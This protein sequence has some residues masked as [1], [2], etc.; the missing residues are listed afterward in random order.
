MERLKHNLSSI[1]N[2]ISKSIE[3]S[4]IVHKGKKIIEQ[5][6]NNKKVLIVL[7]TIILVILLFFAYIVYKYYQSN[8][9]RVKFFKNI[10]ATDTDILPIPKKNL[11]KCTMNKDYYISMWFRIDNWSSSTDT[12]NIK[13]ILT[14][15]Q[16][17]TS[18]GMPSLYLKSTINDIVIKI[19]TT[20]GVE[21]FELQTVPVKKWFKLTVIMKKNSVQLYVNSKLV[22]YK[23]LSGFIN[24]NY[25]SGISLF[26]D[27]NIDGH[28]SNVTFYPKALSPT[29]VANLYDIGDK[30]LK[31]SW[32]YKL[33]NMF[34][35]IGQYS[36]DNILKGSAKCT[37]PGV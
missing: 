20:Q 10:Q 5:N 12:T 3:S 24:S 22:V 35:N 36:Y 21:T 19:K 30:P 9:R 29:E 7:G 16:P 15:G 27:K 2:N 37:V 32:L 26:N 33:I 17:T 25:V 28:F 34:V 23:L 6:K 4:D 8:V 1:K 31:Q 18:I 11:F 13:H 14:F